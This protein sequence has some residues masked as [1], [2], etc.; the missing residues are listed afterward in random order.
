MKER[1]IMHRTIDQAQRRIGRRYLG[2]DGIHAL[3]IK[4][5]DEANSAVLV[6]IDPAWPGSRTILLNKLRRDAAPYAVETVEEEPA[7]LA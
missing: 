7:R 5:N 4:R 6:Y 1:G 2:K 3:G